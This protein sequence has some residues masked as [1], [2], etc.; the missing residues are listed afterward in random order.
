MERGSSEEN[1]D[2]LDMRFLKKINKGLILTII[3]LIILVTYL[4]GVEKQRK[5]D[6]TE[7]KNACEEFVNL[8]NKYLVLPEEMQSLTNKIP[9]E[10][11]KEYGEEAEKA[12]KNIMVDNTEAIKIQHQ[13]LIQALKN[14]YSST[15]EIRTKYERKMAEIT[16]Y[17]FEG[18]TVTVTFSSNVEIETKYLNYIQQE[19]T[20]ALS[21]TAPSDEI[22]LQKVDG[23][24]K[25]VYS[26][27]QYETY[28]NSLVV[29]SY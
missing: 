11:E 12:L 8:T 23:K 14:G 29:D 26:N 7:I 10:Q 18:N 22:M 15:N 5:S 2:K 21:F 1:S 13:F 16:S 3:V 20:R 28:G 17:E 24:W 4:V 6:K 27:L 9:E 19:Q 25:V